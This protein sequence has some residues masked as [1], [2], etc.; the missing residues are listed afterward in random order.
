MYP[1]Y[2]KKEVPKKV[3]DKIKWVEK[4]PLV[5]VIIP[6]LP[7][8]KKLLARAI[9]SVLNQTYPNIE[10]I[11]EEGGRNVQDARNIA[12]ARSH[13]K[14]IALLDDDDEF[15]PTKIE[16]QVMTMEADEEIAMCLCW[17]EDERFGLEDGKVIKPKPW[18]TFKELVD[19]FNICTTSAFLVRRSS[20]DAVG[21]MDDTLQDSHEYDLAIKLSCIGKVYCYPES[22]CIFHQCED[23]WSDCWDKKFMGMIQFMAKW[24]H[25]FDFTRWRNTFICLTLFGVAY[26]TPFLK[27]HPV[28]KIFNMTKDRRERLD[29]EAGEYDE[30]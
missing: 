29:M 9:E 19:G 10:I 11:V 16:K 22:L 3:V 23:N 28:H 24:G 5:S 13:G 20:F 15:F 2:N 8:R 30:S 26:F 21:G 6:T 27:P 7:N 17:G 12:V 1:F 14:Y 25:A 18:W 4:A